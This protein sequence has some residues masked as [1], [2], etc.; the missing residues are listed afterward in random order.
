MLPIV[1]IHS[2]SKKN[3]NRNNFLF[4]IK[5]SCLTSF[6]RKY[7]I[8]DLGLTISKIKIP[9]NFNEVAYD[10]NIKRGI[11]YARHKEFMLAPNAF[12][13]LDYYLLNEFQRDLFALGVVESIKT[14]LRLEQKAIK[15]SCIA[16]FDAEKEYVFDIIK[17]LSKEAKYIILVSDN[18]NKLLGINDY[19]I[20]NY[21]ITPIITKDIKNAFKKAD[22]IIATNDIQ[23]SKD[24]PVWYINNRSV[25]NNRGSC[26]INNITYKVPWEI[27]LDFNPEI[28][29][30]ILSQ[31]EQKNVEEALRY[32]GIILDKI[33]FNENMV[34]IDE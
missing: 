4:K 30:G 20:Y 25:F 6:T 31:M 32:N 7:F 24:I 9:P 18:L 13:F 17:N 10:R 14:I 21:G 12:R 26:M 2:D 28:L 23:I 19:I 11:K 3:Y 27:N 16:I 33:M 22:F 8:K 1:Y 29:G 5:D 34:K 15:N